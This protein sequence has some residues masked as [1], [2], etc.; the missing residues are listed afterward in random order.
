MIILLTLLN[1]TSSL[2]CLLL[3]PGTW[4]L[5]Y[6]YIDVDSTV[7]SEAGCNGRD[8]FDGLPRVWARRRIDTALQCLVLPSPPTCSP[9]AWSRVNHLG[10]GR[11]GVPLNYTWEMPYFP[12]T[13]TKKVVVR[14]RY[15]NNS[16]SLSL[17]LYLSLSLSISLSSHSQTMFG[18]YVSHF[19]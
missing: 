8:G 7:T 12:S 16:L 13:G 6:A 15:V 2:T 18:F 4:F 14:I 17:S 9:A 5:E 3:P 1:P 19:L 10:N 11:D